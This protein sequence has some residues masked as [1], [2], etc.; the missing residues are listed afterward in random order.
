M[1]AVT[2]NGRYLLNLVEHLGVVGAD[3]A[4]GAWWPEVLVQALATPGGL[5]QQHLIVQVIAEDVAELQ[6]RPM[7]CLPE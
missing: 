5:D 7:W 4:A 1:N 6:F 2:T 3:F